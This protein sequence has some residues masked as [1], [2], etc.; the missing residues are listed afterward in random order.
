MSNA[1]AIRIE[2]EQE[3]DRLEVL[4]RL[5]LDQRAEA[6]KRLAQTDRDI[7]RTRRHLAV[8]D[9]GGLSGEEKAC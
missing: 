9:L 7:S 3:L 1:D 4:R 6:T 2:L 5:L 8:L